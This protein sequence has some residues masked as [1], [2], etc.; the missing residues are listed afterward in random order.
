[1]KRS[2]DPHKISENLITEALVVQLTKDTKFILDLLPD[3]PSE[4]MKIN[5]F[6]AFPETEDYVVADML[7][8]NQ[9]P[10][11]FMGNILTKTDFDSN[12]FRDKLK[13]NFCQSVVGGEITGNVH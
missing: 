11:D 9:I 8:L 7:T 4:N 5:T 3:V 2:T 6:I 1:M 10:T 13:L 12:K